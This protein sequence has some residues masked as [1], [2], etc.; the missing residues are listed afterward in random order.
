MILVWHLSAPPPL[1]RLGRE[2]LV[3]TTYYRQL[4]IHMD[5]EHLVNIT[6]VLNVPDMTSLLLKQQKR[7]KVMV[8]ITF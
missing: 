4:A 3:V 2:I 8:G 6:R 7:K 5:V 1:K